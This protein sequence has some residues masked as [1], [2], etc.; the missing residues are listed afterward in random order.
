MIRPALRWGF[1]WFT[2][3]TALRADPPVDAAAR[4]RELQQQRTER[5]R[6]VSPA[7]YARVDADLAVQAAAYLD[8]Q[9]PEAADSSRARAS[10]MTMAG[11]H[12]AARD[13]L[14]RRL[15]E[16]LDSDER[17]A[18][19]LDLMM[20]AVK[21][22]DGE[23]VCDVLTRMTI[24]PARAATL[25]S[26]FGGTFHHYVF[27]ARGAEACLRL[28][29]KIEPAL[30]ADPGADA[31]ARKA[32]GWARR[33]LAATK[34]LYL[35][36]LGRREEAVAVLDQALATL[37]DDVYRKNDLRGDRQRYLLLDRPAPAVAVDRTHGTFPG[38]EAYRGRVLLLE[39]TAHWCHACHAAIPAL[40][41]LYADLESKGLAIVSLTTYYGFF[42]ADR[43][44]TKDMPRDE[45]YARMPAMLAKQGVTWPMVY[46]DRATM[47]AYGVNG[48]PQL[49]LI[50]KQGRIRM[51]DRGYSE[52]KAARWRAQL[53]A[54]LAE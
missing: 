35:A 10:L 23:T 17:F 11:R 24:P 7:E 12:G 6:Q 2:L 43:A 40:C 1:A 13:L 22:N 51:I 48:I 27:N 9:S 36:E 3:A 47:D 8:A 45:E 14:A 28:I 5:T 37:S 20:A 41:R 19:E 16:T 29:A 30:P 26:Y 39:F 15:Q 52:A 18:T 54:L 42:G 25:G 53:E 32:D 31:D 50:D 38:L 49:M 46:T 4:L 34:A 21:L 33:Q 44:R